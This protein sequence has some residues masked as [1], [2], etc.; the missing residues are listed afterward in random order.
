MAHG[1]RVGRRSW[2]EHDNEE[3]GL[4]QAN[5][6]FRVVRPPPGGG[7]SYDEKIDL[8]SLR[9]RRSWKEAVCMDVMFAMHVMYG[10]Y[11]MYVMSV[12]MHVCMYV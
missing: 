7:G 3:K 8:D 5:I 4:I 1:G 2:K 6:D 11:V 12:C 9:R 10:M